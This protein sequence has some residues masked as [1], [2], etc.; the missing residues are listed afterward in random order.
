MSTSTNLNLAPSNG[1][2]ILKSAAI[3]KYNIASSDLYDDLD[4]I[5][6]VRVEHNPRHFYMDVTK[7]NV[8]DV[9][10][11]ARRICNA[12]QAS[13]STVQFAA[14]NG[15][16]IMRTT[17]MKE[18]KLKPCQMDRIQPVSEGPNPHRS[19]ATMRFYNRCDVKA[20]ATSIATA[21]ANPTVG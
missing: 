3:K 4:S 16:Q 10:A 5:L 20:L 19:N 2:W 21:A 14:A 9:D 18:F 11:L 12:S 8:K 6:P 1:R 7:Y 13:G 17:A 15:G